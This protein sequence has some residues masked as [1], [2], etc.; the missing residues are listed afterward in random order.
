MVKATG[1][2]VYCNH[3]GNQTSVV[4]R[5]VIAFVLY[6]M[7]IFNVNLNSVWPVALPRAKTSGTSGG[8]ICV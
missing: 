3:M 4:L 6:N 2:N 8:G 7:K 1:V 5:G